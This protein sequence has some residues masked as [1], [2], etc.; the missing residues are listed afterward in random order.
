MRLL[1]QVFPVQASSKVYELKTAKLCFLL[2]S[3]K[4]E[5]RIILKTFYILSY[6][7]QTKNV[8]PMVKPPN[9][10]STE[11][12]AAVICLLFRVLYHNDHFRLKIKDIC[13]L[14]TVLYHLDC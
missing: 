13:S 2:A 9:F 8:P 11:C 10:C 7:F 4:L 5:M 1:E 12:N 14:F 3:S 6:S